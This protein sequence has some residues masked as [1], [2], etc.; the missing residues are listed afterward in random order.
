M[1]TQRRMLLAASESDAG[2]SR[3]RSPR[4]FEAD[5][6]RTSKHSSVGILCAPVVNGEAFFEVTP[7]MSAGFSADAG[8]CGNVGDGCTRL[9]RSS[10]AARSTRDWYNVEEPDINRQRI[11]EAH[12]ASRK[13]REGTVV[14]PTRDSPPDR[15]PTPARTWNDTIAHDCRAVLDEAHVE[16]RHIERTCDRRRFQAPSGRG[17]V[18]SDSTLLLRRARRSRRARLRPEGA[19]LNRRTEISKA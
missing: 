13:K 10:S 1:P 8:S 9:A 2:Y 12:A 11:V 4:R 17:V 14:R 16:V 15:G 18:A 3:S 7:K 19:A 6:S 5:L